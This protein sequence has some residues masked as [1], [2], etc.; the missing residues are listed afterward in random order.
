MCYE[1]DAYLAKARIA[2]HLRK[3]KAAAEEAKKQRD[4]TAPAAP[5]EPQEHGK[6]REP[7]PV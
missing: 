4:A 5:R 1:Y 2:E 3:Q 7:V 6:D